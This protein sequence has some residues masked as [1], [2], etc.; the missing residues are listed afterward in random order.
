MIKNVPEAIHEKVEQ[1][2][3]EILPKYEQ[4]LIETLKDQINKQIEESEIIK[5]IAM[6]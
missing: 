2:V 3:Q 6:L 4:F 1:Q 5:K